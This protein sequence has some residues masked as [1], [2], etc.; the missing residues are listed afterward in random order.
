MFRYFANRQ[1]LGS[2]RFSKLNLDS[3]VVNSKISGNVLASRNPRQVDK[4]FLSN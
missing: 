2:T 4:G 1:G 3:E